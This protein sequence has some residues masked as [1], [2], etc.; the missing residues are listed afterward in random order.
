MYI[1]KKYVFCP[2]FGQDAPDAPYIDLH[3]ITVPQYYFRRS[4]A[5]RLNVGAKSVV[6]KARIAKVDHLHL[7]WVVWF[8]QDVLGFEIGVNDVQRVEGSQCSEYLFPNLLN[9]WDREEGWVFAISYEEIIL[10]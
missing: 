6:D 1:V 5:S 9:D 7:D 8:Y 2:E 10:E 3:V 4:V